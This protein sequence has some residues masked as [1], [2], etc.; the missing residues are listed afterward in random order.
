MAKSKGT[1]GR[2]SGVSGMLREPLGAAQASVEHL[3]E[4]ARRV[5]EAL[6][7]RGRASRRDL[8]QLLHRLSRQDWSFPEVRHRLEKL[9]GQGRAR[10]VAWR[11]KA[12]TFRT[13]ALERVVEIQARAVQFLGAASRDQVNEL[14]RELDKL[15]RRLERTEKSRQG[16]KPSKPSSREV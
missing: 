4:E 7:A 13:E 15:S 1:N 8:E 12:E 2:I 14:H 6:L 10:A 9:R 5:L 11:G 3:E 16:K